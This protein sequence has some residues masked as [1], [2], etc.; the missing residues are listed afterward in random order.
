MGSR[1]IYAVQEKN[2]RSVEKGKHHAPADSPSSSEFEGEEPSTSKC[3]IKSD[4]I[5]KDIEEIKR[6]ISSL[7]DV[8]KTMNIPV[9]V[10]HLFLQNFICHICHG[11]ITPPA[12]FSR[13]C[14]YLI[15]CENCVDQWYSDRNKCCPR[16]RQERAFTE[17]CR[18]NG[19]D[20]FF[21]SIKSMLHFTETTAAAAD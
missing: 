10:R 6:S 1:K 9:A 14:K 12:I 11:I 19:L 21:N 2:L 16:C 13:C 8:Q 17:T 3:L 15:G 4:N 7:F 18:L 20:D 5:G